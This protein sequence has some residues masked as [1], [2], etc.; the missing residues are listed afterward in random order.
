[1]GAFIYNINA[2]NHDFPHLQTALVCGQSV[3]HTKIC[4]LRRSNALVVK[5]ISAALAYI[6]MQII[7]CTCPKITCKRH[8]KCIEC[9]EY[10][11]NTIPR[12]ERVNEEITRIKR[13]IIKLRNK[14]IS[15]DK[16]KSKLEN[17]FS[18]KSAQEIEEIISEIKQ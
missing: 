4:G 8:G 1:M 13:K 9:R 3:L 14:G 18:N 12:C 16:I 10:H 5:H 11:R 7:N 2:L 17:K 6:K 15:E